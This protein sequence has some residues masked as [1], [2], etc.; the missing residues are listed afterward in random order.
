[1]EVL[2]FVEGELLYDSVE[3][4]C[5]LVECVC[6]LCDLEVYMV[7]VLG[8]GVCVVGDSVFDGLVVGE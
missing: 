4:C 8:M 2:L 7:I 1:M 6:I 3:Y 5:D